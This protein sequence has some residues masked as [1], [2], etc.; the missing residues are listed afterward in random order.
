MTTENTSEPLFYGCF[1]GLRGLEIGMSLDD[2]L[3]CSHA[4]SCDDDV[5]ALLSKPEIAAQLDAIGADAIRSALKEYGAWDDDEL[6]DDDQNRAR[7]LW[8]A[9]CDIRENQP[10]D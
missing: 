10:R 6:Q 2:A 9:A 5:A 7:A 4:G 1:C 3:S 8:L